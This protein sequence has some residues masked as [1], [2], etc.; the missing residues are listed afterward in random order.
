MVGLLMSVGN[1]GAVVAT[2]PLAWAAG[3]WGWRP[4][5]FLIGGITLAMA[6]LML[7]VT[8]DSPQPGTVFGVALFQVFTGN[9]IDQAGRVGELYALSAFKS[10]FSACLAGALVCLVLSFLVKA[11]PNK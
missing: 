9:I 5:F 7:T 4:T 3:T 11:G 1:F 8:R 6:I 10:A 2:A